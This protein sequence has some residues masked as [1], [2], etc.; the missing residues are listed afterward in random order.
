V[1]RD[2]IHASQSQLDRDRPWDMLIHVERNRHQISPL[3]LSR[4]TSGDG[5]A[6]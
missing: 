4:A 6:V 1:S 3:A 5:L 2:D